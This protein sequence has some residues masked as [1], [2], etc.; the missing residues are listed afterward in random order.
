MPARP[1]RRIALVLLALLAFAQIN[2]ALAGCFM[3]RGS[4]APATATSTDMDAPCDGCSMPP[5]GTA[6]QISNACIV[7]CTSD[8][9]LT[10]AA[11]PLVF[12]AIEVPIFVVP[13]FEAPPPARSA[14]DGPP[15]AAPPRRILLHSFLI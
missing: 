6:D 2:V 9:Q 1:K 12:N 4:L 11:T 13:R 14:L 5:S 10:T 8:L 7:H 3:D 15:V